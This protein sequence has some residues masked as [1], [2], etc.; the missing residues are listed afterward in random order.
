MEEQAV[1]A[2][3]FENLIQQMGT[4]VYDCVCK[5]TIIQQL[6]KEN[7]ALLQAL[8]EVSEQLE[9]LKEVKTYSMNELNEAE[10]DIELDTCFVC[11]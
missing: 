5:D 1:Q 6:Q 10:E 2:Q 7:S 11:D 4:L 3:V 8:N 9:A